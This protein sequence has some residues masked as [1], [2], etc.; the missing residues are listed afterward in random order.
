VRH[1]QAVHHPQGLLGGVDHRRG[2]PVEPQPHVRRGLVEDLA[3]VLAD[4]GH[5]VVRHEH[6]ERALRRRRVEH[7]LAGEHPLHPGERGG[8]AIAQL[9]GQRRQL[10]AV[11]DAGEQFVAEVAAQPGQRRAEG[12]LAEPEPSG[13]TGDAA[14]AQQVVQRHQ[15]VQVE[16][17]QVHRQLLIDPADTRH[18]ELRL[19]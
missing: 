5:R 19:P 3:D 16:R 4:D 12:R 18:H 13:G 14:L 8:G 11:A 1:H 6:R 7:G 17:G 15:Q 2:V 9:H 10:V